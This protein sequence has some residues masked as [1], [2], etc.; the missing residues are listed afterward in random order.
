MFIVKIF[1][2]WRLNLL[3]MFLEIF[4]SEATLYVLCMYMNMYFLLLVCYNVGWWPI[5]IVFISTCFSFIFL[6]FKCLILFIAYKI[7]KTL[8][9]MKVI[10]LIQ[11]VGPKEKLAGRGHWAVHYTS[12]QCFL[13][14]FSFSLA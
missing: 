8:L 12:P 14:T 4:R 5:F 10:I 6:F 2:I 11:V 3:Q 7:L 9:P 13:I 1:N